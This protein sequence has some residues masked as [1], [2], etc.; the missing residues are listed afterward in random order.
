[1]PRSLRRPH[2]RTIAISAAAVVAVAGIA[3]SA[4]VGSATS[5]PSAAAAFA[6]AQTAHG[7]STAGS[8][9]VPG[10]RSASGPASAAA[11]VATGKAQVRHAPPQSGPFAHTH[12]YEFYDSVTPSAIPAGGEIATYQTG[13]YAVSPSAVAGR[14][15]IIWIDTTGYDYH[16]NA[17]DTE[18][19]DATPMQAAEWAQH[20]LTDYPGSIAHIY[21]MISEWGQVKADVASL[22]TPAQQARV[23]WWIADPTGQP[24]LVPGSQATQLYWGSGYDISTATPNF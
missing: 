24:H 9:G 8:R 17:L 20:R 10:S 11:S 1:M 13:Y 15:P 12:D 21:T 3:T 23:R 19:G 2:A 16:A 7:A 4:T 14:G 18:P 5:T 22:L 6:R